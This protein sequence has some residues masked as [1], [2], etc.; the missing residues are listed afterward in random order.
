MHR[1]R[2]KCILRYNVLISKALNKRVSI[3]AGGSGSWI[4]TYPILKYMESKSCQPKYLLKHP[5]H[6]TWDTLIV[7]RLSESKKVSFLFLNEYIVQYTILST[8]NHMQLNTHQL[9]FIL[10][11][12]YCN[13]YIYISTP[14]RKSLIRVDF[15][16]MVEMN[17]I[18]KLAM[19][20]NY[21]MLVFWFKNIWIYIQWYCYNF[22][23]FTYQ[24]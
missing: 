16:S 8:L 10:P 7:K 2:I 11:L 21:F 24:I 4:T 9:F 22:D 14:H 20:E 23:Y 12:I 18:K 19:I 3:T 1:I 13:L 6:Y 15:I 5:A 17:I